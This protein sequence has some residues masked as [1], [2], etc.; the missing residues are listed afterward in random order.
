MRVLL[1]ALV[2]TFTVALAGYGIARSASGTVTVTVKRDNKVVQGAT[3]YEETPCCPSR[4][5]GNPETTDSSG[6]ATFEVENMRDL[7]CFASEYSVGGSRGRVSSC[8]QPTPSR[9]TLDFD[10]KGRR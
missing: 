9:L 1:I 3:V 5:I 10:Y 6:V 7:H 8:Q 4:Q 2:L